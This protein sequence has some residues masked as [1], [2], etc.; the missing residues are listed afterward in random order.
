MADV[1]HCPIT[2]IATLVALTRC[3]LGMHYFSLIDSGW[4]RLEGEEV[5]RFWW[6]GCK[7][8]NAT[9]LAPIRG[10]SRW[11]GTHGSALSS[12]AA[13]RGRDRGCSCSPGLTWTERPLFPSR[14]ANGSPECALFG[15]GR[16][17]CFR[18]RP[19][20]PMLMSSERIFRWQ[21]NAAENGQN[22]KTMI[23]WVKLLGHW[24][25]SLALQKKYK[26]A[27]SA[28]SEFGDQRW[29]FTAGS[30]LTLWQ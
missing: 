9:M 19:N 17:Q 6:W 14:S 3:T 8:K 23:Q 20:A 13:R 11:R 27:I 10:R 7:K 29:T 28:R 4:E 1:W 12:Q 5:E 21:R 30:K 24:L 22:N 16:K 25:S 2:D 15:Q 18:R 26:N